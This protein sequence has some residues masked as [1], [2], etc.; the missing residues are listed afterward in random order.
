MNPNNAIDWVD[1][2]SGALL[3]TGWGVAVIFGLV[4]YAVLP[5]LQAKRPVKHGSQYLGSKAKADASMTRAF[6]TPNEP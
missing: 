4:K 6:G 5:R 1:Q 3:A 2:N